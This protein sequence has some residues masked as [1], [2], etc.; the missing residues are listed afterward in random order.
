MNEKGHLFQSD[1]T[2]LV[3]SDLLLQFA[4]HEQVSQFTVVLW[5]SF[6]FDKKQVFRGASHLQ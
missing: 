3:M 4:T 5:R 2:C 6:S 1:I